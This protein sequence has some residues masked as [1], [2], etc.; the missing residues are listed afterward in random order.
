MRAR[1]AYLHD[2]D[3]RE[4][5]TVAHREAEST[6]RDPLA[7]PAGGAP[8]PTQGAPAPVAELL[9]ER[10]EAL[11]RVWEHRVRSDRAVPEARRLST[12][13]LRDHLPALLDELIAALQHREA[14]RA[15]AEA[16]GRQVWHSPN[17]HIHAEERFDQGYSLGPILRELSHLRAAVA[18]L[19]R[20]EGVVPERD[21]SQIIDTAI[22]EAMAVAATELE[23]VAQAELLAS[24]TRYRALVDSVSDYAILRLDPSG[25]V[26]SWTPAAARMT[27]YTE[28]EIVGR[29]LDLLFPREARSSG[30][31]A[32]E[33][34]I[35]RL[36]GRF[37]GRLRRLRKDGAE[38]WAD[39]TLT[40]ILDELGR[41]E[42]FSKV[43]R[44][45][46]AQVDAER[47]LREGEERLAAILGT[48]MDAI[49]TVDEGQR[50]VVF[51]AAA[52][53]VFRCPATEAIGSP[54]ER[55]IPARFRAA[56]GAQMRQFADTGVTARAM[57]RLGRVAAVR[58]DGEEFPIEATI[59]FVRVGASSLYTIVLR[60]VSAQARAEDAR[61]SAEARLQAILDNTSAVIYVKD[62]AGRLVLVNRRFEEVFGLRADEILGRTDAELFPVDLAQVFAAHDRPVREGAARIEVVE[63]APHPDGTHTYISVK[64]PMPFDGGVGVGGIST[65]ITSLVR[66]QEALAGEVEL[67]ELFMGVLAH[68]L[69]T[70]LSAIGL[71]AEALQRHGDP[72][73]ASVARRMV[74]STRRM[75]TMVTELLDVTAIR[76]GEG[77]RLART[78]VSLEALATGT[79]SEIGQ[80]HPQ[81]RTTL[82]VSG[83]VTGVWDAGKLA[84]AVGNLVQNGVVHGRDGAPLELVLDGR[85][86]E[87]VL[88]VKNANRDGPIPPDVRDR[89]FDPF[90]RAQ[91]APRGG[92]GLGLYI[93]DQIVRA[94]GGRMELRSDAGGTVF[95][96]VLPRA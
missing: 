83:D 19:L 81:L 3:E 10:R 72:H 58:A 95:R 57:G 90:R 37:T 33:L 14:R 70:P 16:I 75:A 69:R 11:I 25:K 20:A 76:S 38:F 84:Q 55:F 32:E 31:L 66:A 13:A 21:T 61:R 5:R 35:A 85:A 73:V 18:D 40:V 62:E 7:R 86:H 87:V 34:A 6:A 44:D 80:A 29:S 27:G 48:A 63:R 91:G 41:V 26:L 9:R 89:L 15:T 68:D 74:H 23:R 64:F 28:A 82:S 88:E 50:V 79:L 45:V 36:E 49:I 47:A 77:L 22:D 96:M 46:T 12:P 53:T 8:G 56:H 94:H 51:N 4:R 42:G 17:A 1:R 71:G 52:E 65:D 60:D 54:I 39:V 67:R 43:L 2:V 93:V 59:S 78:P 92:L 24:E 30:A